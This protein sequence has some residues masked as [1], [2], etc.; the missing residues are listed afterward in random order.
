MPESREPVALSQPAKNLGKLTLFVVKATALY[1]THRHQFDSDADFCAATGLSY[2]Y[3][4]KQ[5]SLEPEFRSALEEIDK[6]RERQSKR[7][8]QA[9]IPIRARERWPALDFWKGVFL[10]KYRE[11]C[12]PMEAADLVDKT[13]RQIEEELDKDASFKEGL[14]EIESEIAIRVKA[15]HTKMALSGKGAA[16]KQFLDSRNHARKPA[17]KAMNPEEALELYRRIFKNQRPLQEEP[18]ESEV[19]RPEVAPS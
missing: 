17:K 19:E 9:I 10:E 13:W 14:E 11:C 8:A 15:M 7:S 3:F 12:D 16:A 4:R 6:K 18:G 1:E 5:R 2:G